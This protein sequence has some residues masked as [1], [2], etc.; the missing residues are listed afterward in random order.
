MSS[1]SAKAAVPEL[2]RLLDEKES[3]TSQTFAAECLGNRGAAAKGAVPGLI[4]LLAKEPT[5]ESAALALGRIGPDAKAALPDLIRLAE[6][7]AKKE[8]ERVKDRNP[9]A[10]R[11]NAHR[12]TYSSSAI[13]DAIC[14]IREP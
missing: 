7:H 10:R 6:I 4:T 3:V 9:E 11:G 12:R 8:W 2:A 13:V 5:R 14:K 1:I